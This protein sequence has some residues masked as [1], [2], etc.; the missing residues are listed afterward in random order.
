MEEINNKQKVKAKLFLVI[1]LI[2]IF[3]LLGYQIYDLF[4]VEAFIYNNPDF[5]K[6]LLYFKW[7]IIFDIIIMFIALYLC[8]LPFIISK[9]LYKKGKYRKQ[10]IW[11]II[12]LFLTQI[13]ITTL[14]STLTSCMGCY[15]RE[16]INKQKDIIPITPCVPTE[17]NNRGLDC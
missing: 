4:Y 5:F 15:N 12:I 11:G 8:F 1:L 10:I 17:L 9:R 7:S 14:I 2:L 6:N 13:I 3:I 16:L